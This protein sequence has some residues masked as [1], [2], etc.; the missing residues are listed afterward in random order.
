MKKRYLSSSVAD[1][2]RSRANRDKAVDVTMQDGANTGQHRLKRAKKEGETVSP[3]YVSCVPM[4]N[5]AIN[6]DT[7]KHT[8]ERRCSSPAI[9]QFKSGNGGSDSYTTSGNSQSGFSPSRELSFDGGDSGLSVEQPITSAE[10]PIFSVE[11]IISPSVS[12]TTLSPLF[13][14][15]VTTAVE[16]PIGRTMQYEN[17]TRPS[18]SELPTAVGGKRADD[19]AG[20]PSNSLFSSVPTAACDNSQ[21]LETGPTCH[22]VLDRR[23]KNS[24]IPTCVNSA[25][26][27][28][29][30]TKSLLPSS[31]GSEV[32]P[33]LDRMFSC[34]AV[35]CK[36]EIK[37]PKEVEQ[38]GTGSLEPSRLMSEMSEEPGSI[39]K[40]VCSREMSGLQSSS[41]KRS[42]VVT[43]GKLQTSLSPNDKSLD[44]SHASQVENSLDKL[45]SSGEKSREKLQS[46]GEKLL[47]KSL[48]IEKSLD[49]TS[50]K[51]DGNGSQHKKHPSDRNDTRHQHRQESDRHATLSNRQE[52]SSLKPKHRHKSGSSKTDQSDHAHTI[53]SA[54]NR[55]QNSKD[56][57]TEGVGIPGK[58]L[59]SKH[60]SDCGLLQNNS[61]DKHSS[62]SDKGF[63]FTQ[64]KEKEKVS[65]NQDINVKHSKPVAKGEKLNGDKSSQ[66]SRPKSDP[67]AKS[68]S[69]E[70]HKDHK[71]VKT[72]PVKSEP[73]KTNKIGDK[74]SKTHHTSTNKSVA[75]TTKSSVKNFDREEDLVNAQR[76]PLCSEFE[77]ILRRKTKRPSGEEL[78]FRRLIH[79]EESANGG[80]TVVHSYQDEIASLSPDQMA[81]F[82]REY[83]R[84]VFEEE[85]EGVSKHVMGIV[86]R[87][88]LYLPDLLEYFADI[89]GDMIVKRG[90]LGKS[91]IETTSMAEFRR[92]VHSTYSVG[93]YRCGG[94]LQLSLVGTKAEES[95]GLFP[96]FLD[97]M[98]RNPFLKAVMPWGEMSKLQGIQPSLSND[99][100]ILWSRPGEQVVP[101][102]DLPKS[103][104]AK[105]RLVDNYCMKTNRSCCS[106]CFYG[107][108]VVLSNYC[109]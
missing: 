35:G 81:E 15:G 107:T 56:E 38:Q 101:T 16:L 63:K 82:V 96:E 30:D 83:F 69:A 2:K 109:V 91:D 60:V 98:E 53:N 102:A 6:T 59:N 27:C 13:D 39:R 1:V 65:K 54:S 29:C 37:A 71:T 31:Q 44:S 41:G 97:L 8:Q 19:K 28:P 22:N 62:G 14:A 73:G 47:D 77:Y 23:P 74:T 108:P 49:Q 20:L 61:H 100:P 67:A 70:H 64:V 58:L 76:Q 79:I 17:T 25:Q 42:E 11:H 34:N 18:C 48:L 43:G 32:C 89:Y 9:A 87:S 103:P 45:Q 95:G 24:V 106:M 93:T 80:A 12:A 46:S 10:Q 36:S 68:I 57:L 75:G 78:K 55:S 40:T 26:V 21:A 104:L 94:L 84:I 85:S 66:K 4:T 50:N 86:H 90:I 7:E 5:G 92:A 105:K 3:S 99:G 52:G 72:E 33:I 51:P 88:A